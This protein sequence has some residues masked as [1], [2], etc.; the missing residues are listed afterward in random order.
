MRKVILKKPCQIFIV[1]IFIIATSLTFAH[2]GRTDSSGGHND[3]KAGGYHYHHGMGPHQH[4]NGE[5]PYTSPAKSYQKRTTPKRSTRQ[6][7]P[8]PP[9]T[10]TKPT[11][12]MGQVKPVRITENHWQVA[13]NNKLFK[14]ELEVSVSTGRVDIVTETFV[15]EV[16]KVSKYQEGIKQA[17]KYAQATNKKPLLA[18]Y[19]DGE[20]DGYELFKKADTLCRNKGISL[21]LVNS[22]VS[23]NDLIALVS[24]A[25]SG[26]SESGGELNY[27]LNTNSN[28]RHNSS[29]RWYMSTAQGRKCTKSEGSACGTCG[30]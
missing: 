19:I 4:P 2:S 17:L 6:V 26:S 23:V 29:C 27:W 8:K 11:T 18:L 15:I 24:V 30:G 5:C 7:K 20:K 25:N 28:K 13:L 14:G 1:T 22:Y 16:D 10:Y 12:S 21:L 3:R 9:T